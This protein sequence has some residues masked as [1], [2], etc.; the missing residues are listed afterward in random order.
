MTLQ[1]QIARAL[2]TAGLPALNSFDPVQKLGEGAWH[3]AYLLPLPDGRNMVMRFPKEVSYGKAFSYDEKHLRSEYGSTQ[4]YY[5]YAN[6]IQPGICPGEFFY[7]VSEDLTF[8]VESYGGRGLQVAELTPV[9]AYEVGHQLGDYF[10]AVDQVPIEIPGF[11]FLEW[12]GEGLRGSAPGDPH[13]NLR[14]EVAEYREELQ[15]LLDAPIPFN[16]EQVLRTFDTVVANRRTDEEHIVLT[17]RDLSPENLLLH[18]GRLRMIDPVPLAY[19]NMVFAGNFLNLYR[20][21]Y[22]LYHNV[23]RYARH[24]YHLYRPQL[25]ALA[26]GFLDAYSDGDP[27]RRRRIEG[28]HFFMLVSLAQRHY[29]L[30]QQAELSTETL[31]RTGDHSIIRERLPILLQHLEAFELESKTYSS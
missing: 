13:Q 28:E 22:P 5:S 15:T 16:R 17:N 18:N 12:D 23:Q 10:L 24:Q 20:E 14:D 8:T 1:E 31:I 9:S 11:G 3:I 4:L 19:S 29:T 2:Q 6:R 30:L 26:D 7:H 21:I 25:S 27:D